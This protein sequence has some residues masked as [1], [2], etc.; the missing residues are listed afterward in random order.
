M[1]FCS[2][3]VEFISSAQPERDEGFSECW[4]WELAGCWLV[5]SV[6]RE[7]WS[8]LYT[9]LLY[10][11]VISLIS[12]ISHLN[13]RNRKLNGKY[14]KKPFSPEIVISLWRDTSEI[15]ATEWTD[16]WLIIMC[17]RQ[18]DESV[19]TLLWER[20]REREIVL[21]W[22]SV[23]GWSSLSCWLWWRWRDWTPSLWTTSP[24]DRRPVSP[25][26]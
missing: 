25:S 12:H 22:C 24:S 20:E 7:L 19:L 14:L 23:P 15:W 3:I 8:L 6:W 13:T 1:S 10:R 2:A 17:I 21:L 5:L 4:L 16:C 11:V 26:L 18:C 9:A